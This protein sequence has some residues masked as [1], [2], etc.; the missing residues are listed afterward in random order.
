[1]KKLVFAALLIM[2]L[3]WTGCYTMTIQNTR[4][5]VHLSSYR[6]KVLVHNSTNHP[7]KVYVEGTD[8]ILK[9]DEIK[10]FPFGTFY[11][12][13]YNAGRSVVMVA[14]YVL[15]GDT[16]STSR[17]FYYDTMSSREELWTLEDW[18]FQ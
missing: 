15:N 3:T 1:M 12:S 13:N 2:S 11:F 10:E 18:A 5:S 16:R 9:A 17:T 4:G 8:T 14:S 6:L 7:I